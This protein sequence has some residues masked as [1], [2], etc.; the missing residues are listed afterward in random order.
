MIFIHKSLFS[1]PGPMKKTVNLK[2]SRKWEKVWLHNSSSSFIIRILMIFK[3]PL[4][5][6]L[7][8]AWLLELLSFT[9]NPIGL[10]WKLL[11]LFHAHISAI[12]NTQINSLNWEWLLWIS[13]GI[14]PSS[15]AYYLKIR[16]KFEAAIFIIWLSIQECRGSS[17]CS[18][19]EELTM[20]MSH[21]TPHFSRDRTIWN[22][23]T[24]TKW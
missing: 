14:H 6:I 10:T 19:T 23:K 20:D 4:L 2:Q 16:P 13:Y 18:Y 24:V 21:N 5:L 17:I 11:F 8:E 1:I 22:R 7:L 15:T 3:Y 9:F 12:S